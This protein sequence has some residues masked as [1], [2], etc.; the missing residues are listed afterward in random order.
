VINNGHIDSFFDVMF[1]VERMDGTTFWSELQ[2]APLLAPGETAEITYSPL[3]LTEEGDFD[4]RVTVMLPGDANPD[5]DTAPGSFSV[6]GPGGTVGCSI[7]AVPSIGT[8]PFTTQFTVS[9]EN[10]YTG[11]IRRMAAHIDVTL[12]SGGYF[13]NWRVGSTNIAAGSNYLA[14]WNQGIPAL[15]TLIGDNLFFL[16]A[17]DVTPAPYNQPPYPP[18]GDTCTSS[19]VVTAAGP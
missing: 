11:Q 4:T 3:A 9:L 8:V 5:N 10:L 7:A 15:G 6:A 16:D 2:P 19:Q 18:A 17:R 14:V 13:P 12:A 1:E